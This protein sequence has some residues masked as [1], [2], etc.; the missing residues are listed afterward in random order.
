MYDDV[1]YNSFVSCGASIGAYKGIFAHNIVQNTSVGISLDEMPENVSY[2][3]IRNCQIGIEVFLGR[4]PTI[5]H[6]N[7]MNNKLDAYFYDSIL[8]RWHSNYWERP[9]FRPKIIFGTLAIWYIGG[10]WINF[11]FRP[12][13][14]PYDIPVVR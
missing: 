12:A 7:F 13:Q 3:T 14:Q 11:D 5:S 8:I 1:Q 2:N 6:N 9:L 4:W 10:P